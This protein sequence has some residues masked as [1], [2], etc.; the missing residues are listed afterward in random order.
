MNEE[1]GKKIINYTIT[2]HEEDVWLLRM[3]RMAI[4]QD[5]WKDNLDMDL[6]AEIIWQIEV[7]QDKKDM[8]INKNVNAKR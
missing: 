1:D 2:L 6:I 3:M 5:E 8:E 4:E 7:Q